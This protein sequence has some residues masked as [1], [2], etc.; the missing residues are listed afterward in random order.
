MYISRYKIKD[1]DTCAPYG[2]ELRQFVYLLGKI[3][4][5]LHKNPKL[6]EPEQNHFATDYLRLS[7]FARRFLTF[8]EMYSILQK[9]E[10]TKDKS[11]S[12]DANNDEF[13]LNHIYAPYFQISPRR[14]RKIDINYNHFEMLISDDVEKAE[15]AANLI[16]GDK[17][18]Q[19]DNGQLTFQDLF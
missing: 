2:Q 9:R 7:S 10:E 4:E 15:K 13:H 6:S 1:I 18:R 16:V 3:F 17:D 12:V 8:A 11:D 19:I 14:K 5:R